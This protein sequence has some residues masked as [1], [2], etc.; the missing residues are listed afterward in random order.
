MGPAL[1]AVLAA[2]PAP[3]PVAAAARAFAR[4]VGPFDCASL[5]GDRGGP[6]RARR[7]AEAAVCAGGMSFKEID[8][9]WCVPLACLLRPGRRLYLASPFWSAGWEHNL[10]RGAA[11][12]ARL[13]AAGALPEHLLLAANLSHSRLSRR[14]GPPRRAG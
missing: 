7:P 13:R 10:S 1:D 3:P 12:A 4:A 6:S 14:G 5:R 2:A 9:I 11:A 8:D